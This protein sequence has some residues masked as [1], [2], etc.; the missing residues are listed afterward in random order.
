MTDHRGIS[1]RDVHLT[2]PGAGSNGRSDRGAHDLYRCVADVGDLA[3][4]PVPDANLHLHWWIPASSVTPS[5]PASGLRRTP[6]AVSRFASTRTG[7]RTTSVDHRPRRPDRRRHH[8]H[9]PGQRPEPG[10]SSPTP[11]TPST[12]WREHAPV[13]LP[14][15]HRGRRHR[16]PAVP[17]AAIGN[18]SRTPNPPGDRQSVKHRPRA[19]GRQARGQL[20]RQ[21]ACAVRRGLRDRNDPARPGP[22]RARPARGRG[23]EGAA[24][25]AAERDP[26]RAHLS[27]ELLH[28]RQLWIAHHAE[29]RCRQMRASDPWSP[30]SRMLPAGPALSAERTVSR[31]VGRPA[32]RSNGRRPSPGCR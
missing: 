7:T 21:A 30:T 12:A 25:C 23:S 28:R 5:Q 13:H 11:T 31:H 18:R 26:E 3:G 4:P 19:R 8:N 27:A 1:P 20:A 6:T 9:H 17:A 10:R 32:R 15:T 22:A 29:S 2:A 24:Q 14:P 16:T